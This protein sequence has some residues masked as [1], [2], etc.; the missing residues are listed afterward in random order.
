MTVS[1][2]G[3][4]PIEPLDHES[5]DVDFAQV[6]GLHR[7]WLSTKARVEGA[8]PEAYRQF[9]DEL[10][11]SWAIETGIIE[12]L[13]ELDRGIT[14]TLIQQGFAGD[15]I[16][17]GASN[18]A[19]GELIAILRDQI[20]AID[21]TN[22]W[23]EESRPLTKW[24]IQS[25]HQGITASQ[26]TH[27][28][29]DHFGHAFDT[30]LHHGQFKTQSNSPT[31][32]DG[33]V[34]EYC[35]PLQVESELDNLIDWYESYDGVRH[36]LAVAAWLHHRFTQIHPFEDGNGRV[37]RALLTWHLVR[38][39]F[40]PVVV[41]RDDLTEYISTLEQADAGDLSPFVR[42]LVRLQTKTLLDALNVEH[43][44]SPV[45]VSSTLS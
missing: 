18:K 1:A 39:K 4:S 9:N 40:L 31:R 34:H 14:E 27:R 12:G 17:R 35:P 19:P 45:L 2:I 28:V 22:R 38:T 26:P 5:I 7:Q 25:L 21:Q 6:D 30:D 44:P 24:F 20:G 16:E 15:L 32:P 41:T 33:T 3:W 8:N 42:L 11:R 29:V 10:A 13:Y 37:V 23:I 36:P 43:G